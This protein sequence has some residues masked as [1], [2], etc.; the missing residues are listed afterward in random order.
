MNASSVRGSPGAGE[1]GDADAI[2]TGGAFNVI[3]V[4]TAV[5]V[6]IF[7]AGADA[8][9]RERLKRRMPVAV[10]GGSERVTLSVDTAEDTILRKLERYRRGG[11][12]VRA[13]VA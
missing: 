5:K 2:S 8:F 12:A 7:V 6:D 3:H 1:R 13:T 9:D 4:P 10:S 11:E